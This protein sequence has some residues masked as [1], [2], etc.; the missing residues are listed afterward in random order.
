MG[1]ARETI[2]LSNKSSKVSQKAVAAT[3]PCFTFG[4]AFF[5]VQRKLQNHRKGSTSQPT[6]FPCIIWQRHNSAVTFCFGCES[7]LE[8]PMKN[9]LEDAET[10]RSEQLK[11]VR[12]ESIC[13]FAV[14]REEQHHLRYWERIMHQVSRSVLYT[15]I[16]KIGGL[17]Y[18]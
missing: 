2:L 8:R 16:K 4:G 13:L 18:K 15:Q 1:L 6:S 10:C 11:S 9:L 12:E 3:R 17:H 5:N 14:S 7:V